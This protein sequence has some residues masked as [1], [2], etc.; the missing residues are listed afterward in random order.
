[1]RKEQDRGVSA[2]TKTTDELLVK[3]AVFLAQDEGSPGFLDRFTKA[4]S[5]DARL[6]SRA[7]EQALNAQTRAGHAT[8]RL[9]PGELR[10][11][12]TS[13][14]AS[15]TACALPARQG[16]VAVAI[17]LVD[18]AC[19]P[20]EGAAL[21]VATPRENCTVVTNA[22]GWAHIGGTG[23]SLHVRVGQGRTDQQ[24]SASHGG[25]SS[26]SLLPLPRIQHRDE[27]ELAAA[28]NGGTY[29]TD[30]T[31][32]WQI[33][34]GGVEFLCLERKDGYDLTLLVT[35]VTAE[36]A[37]S[38]VGTYG[39]SFLTQGG[40]GRSRRWIVPL[41]PSPLGLA[42]SLYSTD[43]YCL[44]SGSVEVADTEL[45]I[46]ALGDRFDE[47]VRRSVQHSDTTA[48]WAALCKRLISGRH[49]SV[50]QAALAER[51]SSL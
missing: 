11:E 6:A 14:G 21:L 17:R 4:V 19:R 22:A 46:A 1:M 38:A 26:A 49:Q 25:G 39:V 48:A 40:E 2:V 31:D 18:T 45:L 20:V 7:L 43:A 10:V 29:D 34:A 50:L 44:D 41:A 24:E 37:E 23:P 28:H 35:G 30:E 12:T 15:L 36:F 47:V 32:R 3:A 5:G 8:I 27:L 9:S 42:G 13:S 16:G 33:H 51:E